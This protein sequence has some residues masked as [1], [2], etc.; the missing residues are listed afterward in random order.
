MTDVQRD[1]MLADLTAFDTKFANYKVNLTPEEI[2]RLSRFSAT[3]IALLDLAVTYAVQNPTA[4]PADVNVAELQ[5]DV[6]LAKQVVIVNAKAQQE[7]D[8]SRISLIA[9]LS[10]ASATARLIYRTAQA[11]GRT[12]ANQ[13]F[14]DSFGA[15]FGRSGGT[16]PTPTPPGP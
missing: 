5:K 1:A 2:A 4:L 16:P 6:A 13:T 11:A 7:A 15:R 8:I 10:D 12:P 14:L 9:V 3:D